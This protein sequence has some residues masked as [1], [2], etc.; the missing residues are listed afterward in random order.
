MQIGFNLRHLEKKVL[1]LKGEVSARDLELG[2]MD[3]LIQVSQ[4]IH[5]ELSVERLSNRVLVRGTLRLTLNCECVRCLK[6]FQKTL[7][8]NDWTCDLPLDGEEKVPVGNDCVDLTPFMRED[9]L[10]SFPQHPLCEPECSG[11]PKAPLKHSQ[12]AS[13]A[14]E[15]GEVSSAWAE[16]NKLKL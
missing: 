9:I 16:L 6:S 1:H 4:P 14:S 12:P 10:L 5:Y 2:E 13:G 15:T 8:I 11:L 3:E 7:E